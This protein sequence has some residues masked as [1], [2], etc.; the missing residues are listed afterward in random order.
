MKYGR[1]LAAWCLAACLGP[2]FAADLYR[3][4]S[5]YTPTRET[6]AGALVATLD[7]AS[8]APRF[9]A[10]YGRRKGNVYRARIEGRTLRFANLPV[11]TYDLLI[12]TASACYEGLAILR[13]HDEEAAAAARPALETEMRKIE[14]FFDHKRLE[15]LQLDGEKAVLLIQQWRVNTALTQG[16]AEVKGSIHSFDILRYER[17]A[18]IW[19]LI[20]RR[21]LYR[22]ELAT[23]EPLALVHLA[24]LGGFLVTTD[25]VTAGPLRLAATPAPEGK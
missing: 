4:E 11:D 21:Q 19:Q 23:R 13:G 9:A 14:G 20:E 15:R 10:A 8:P 7:P 25:S 18:K 17:P 2:L 22:E 6:D 24:A 3:G 16:G 12:V 5:L 1:M